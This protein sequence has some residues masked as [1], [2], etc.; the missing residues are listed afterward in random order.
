MKKNIYKIITLALLMMPMSIFADSVKISCGSTKIEPNKTTNCT[1]TGTSEGSG[2]INA[3]N[4]VFY[5]ANFSDVPVS[6]ASLNITVA[7]AQSSSGNNSGGGNSSGG[8]STTPITKTGDATLKS[9]TVTPGA[10]NFSKNVTNYTVNVDS[11]ATSIAI[12]AVPTDSTSKVSIPKNLN[13][14]G[15]STT[16]RIVVT[17]SDKTTKT[18]TINVVKSAE[19]ENSKSTDIKVMSIEGISDFTFDPNKTEYTVKTDSSKLNIN[20]V[21]EDMTSEYNIYGN[22]NLKNNDTILIQVK[23]KDGSVKEYKLNIVKNTIEEQ[24]TTIETD[25]NKS[26]GIPTYI[27]VIAEL[28]WLLLLILYIRLAI[29]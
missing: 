15:N 16:F 5:D 8:S 11:D 18:Y 25:S 28:L 29:R 21:L 12:N 27:F 3:N 17:A 1:I 2:S 19:E 13:L 4:I 24:S 9:L 20:V 23:A 14:T 7:K 6:N 10:I 26:N 22:D